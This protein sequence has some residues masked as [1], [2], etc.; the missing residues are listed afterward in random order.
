MESKIKKKDTKKTGTIDRRKE[1]K[2]RQKEKD[3]Q[4]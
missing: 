3:R 2:D 4:K 1:R